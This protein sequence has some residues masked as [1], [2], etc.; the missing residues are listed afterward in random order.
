[1]YLKPLIKI[2][3]AGDRQEN[4][5][6]FLRMSPKMSLP[7]PLRTRVCAYVHFPGKNIPSFH[8]RLRRVVTLAPK[9]LRTP[10]PCRQEPRLKSGCPLPSSW[11]PWS[12][13]PAWCGCVTLAWGPLQPLGPFSHGETRLCAAGPLALGSSYTSRASTLARDAPSASPPLQAPTSPPPA[14][15]GNL[16]PFEPPAPD[17]FPPLIRGPEAPPALKCKPAS[18]GALGGP[19]L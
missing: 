16:S 8:R 7:H 13:P 17:G 1:M 2:K 9:R 18:A 12:V 11:S 5:E 10:L 19:G 3:G 6:K 15:G 4:C 14:W